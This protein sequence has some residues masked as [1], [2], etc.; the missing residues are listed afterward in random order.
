MQATEALKITSNDLLKFGVMDEI[1]P[2]PLG[3]AHSDPMSSFTYIKHALLANFNRRANCQL[4]VVALLG[5]AWGD[6]G[7]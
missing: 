6:K 5:A 7:W 4:Q 2:E 1:V 3:G